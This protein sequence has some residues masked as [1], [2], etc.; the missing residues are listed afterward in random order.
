MGSPRRFVPPVLWMAAIFIFST[1]GFGSDGTGAVFEPLV[2]F[3]FPSITP[4]TLDSLH[5]L[6]RKLGHFTEYAV[7]AFLWHRALAG[8]RR[9]LLAAFLISALYAVSD[10]WHQ[11][12][13]PNRTASAVD[14]MVDTTGAAVMMA[15]L[16]LKTKMRGQP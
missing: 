1:S 9:R 16:S 10:E 8:S 11:S 13:V 4:D 5:F 14:V 15:L 2:R 12:F 3:L 7:L 6:F